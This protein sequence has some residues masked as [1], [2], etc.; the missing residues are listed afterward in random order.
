MCSITFREKI[1]IKIIVL[2]YLFFIYLF[3]QDKDV[4]YFRANPNGFTADLQDI[5]DRDIITYDDAERK[6][7]GLPPQ[8][9]D[10]FVLF[11]E[12]DIGF[13]T[14]IVNT[15]EAQYNMKL[16]VKDRDVVGG[17][18]NHDSVIRLIATRC[19]RVI[20]VVSPSFLDSPT[21]KFFYTLA[22]MD[23]IGNISMY[24]IFIIVFLEPCIVIAYDESKQALV[25][26]CKN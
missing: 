10:A 20:V 4:E 9:Y 11:D 18:Y 17:E 16:C 2:F 15:M 5:D 8:T 6:R 23:G 21:N 24:F 26:D 12:D 22:S 19:N 7:E 14:D 3:F 1:I 25:S 13:A